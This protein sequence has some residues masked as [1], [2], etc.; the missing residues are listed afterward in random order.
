VI[1]TSLPASV[2]VDLALATDYN[3]GTCPT[4]SMQTIM[5]LAARLYRLSY[6]EI[7]HLST[8]NAAAAR[9]RR[10]PRQP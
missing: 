6:S 7:W 5:Q 10:R 9:P 1:E 4:L 2:G 8:I 3:P